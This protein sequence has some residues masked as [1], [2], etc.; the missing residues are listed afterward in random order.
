MKRR[1]SLIPLSHDHHLG[2]ILVQRIKLGKSKSPRSRWPEDPSLQRDQT[3][4]FFEAGLSHHFRAEERFLF[5]VAETYLLPENKVVDLLREQHDQLRGWVDQ[6][7]EVSGSQVRPFLLQFA[8]LLE[9]HIRKEERVLFEEI[10][11]QVPDEELVECGRKIEEYFAVS[12]KAGLD[13][14]LV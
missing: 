14:C 3:A 9:D 4:E 2:L 6:L 5:P 13:Q 1:P 8:H 10:Q 12:G 11:Q 7:R